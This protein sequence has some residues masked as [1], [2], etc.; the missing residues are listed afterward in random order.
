MSTGTGIGGIW[1][2]SDVDSI[3]RTLRILD[4]IAICCIILTHLVE[5]LT[6]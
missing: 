3:V 4:K 1:A 2:V 5:K 6:Q